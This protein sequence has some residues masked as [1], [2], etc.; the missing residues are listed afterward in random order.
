MEGFNGL[1]LLIVCALIAAF[2]K[3]VFKFFDL[4]TE[5][6]RLRQKLGMD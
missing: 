5:N 2:V 6:K 1:H 3:G 4:E